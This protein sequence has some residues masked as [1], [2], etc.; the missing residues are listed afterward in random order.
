MQ[1]P[2]FFLWRYIC[3]APAFAR[4]NKLPN[5]PISSPTQTTPMSIIQ[6]A[7]TCRRHV[8]HAHAC[9]WQCGN[10]RLHTPR[11]PAAA[12]TDLLRFVL[13]ADVA[14]A[15]RGGSCDG[16]VKAACA[17]ERC[18]RREAPSRKAL[19]G[20]TATGLPHIP[21]VHEAALSHVYPIK[22]VPVHVQQQAV[23]K[24]GLSQ[25]RNSAHQCA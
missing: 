15:G 6:F 10:K 2:T 1:L 12:L 19:R 8:P 5:A 13:G 25:P 7:S 23:V 20:L 4:V 3:C 16:P 9:V 17:I 22:S 18:V 21:L 14:V 11:V 24:W